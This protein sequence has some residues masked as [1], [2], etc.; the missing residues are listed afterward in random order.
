MHPFYL[1]EASG[2]QPRELDLRSEGTEPG[3]GPQLK[4]TQK[5]EAVMSWLPQKQRK[6]R[7]LPWKWLGFGVSLGFHMD[8][9]ER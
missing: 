8:P 1:W 2:L 4:E 6:E 5:A 3:V 9:V 7:W